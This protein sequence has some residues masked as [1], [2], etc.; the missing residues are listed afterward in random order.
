[1]SCC[2]WTQKGAVSSPYH[3]LLVPYKIR[4]RSATTVVCYSVSVNR[5]SYCPRCYARK[6]FTRVYR[7][8]V[9]NMWSLACG[10][11]I[12][13]SLDVL[14]MWMLLGRSSSHLLWTPTPYTY[15]YRLSGYPCTKHG[16]Q[17]YSRI[18]IHLSLTLP[19]TLRRQALRS[20]HHER[21]TPVRR[22]NAFIA[23]WEAYVMIFVEP[24]MEV[25]GDDWC[26]YI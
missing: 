15:G 16:P 12:A 14:I 22:R 9:E 4:S 18:H 21:F 7:M 2:F 13:H 19:S 17:P 25:Y 3:S 24:S 8:G 23:R 6:R 1:M 26:K 11:G 20:G 10:F 5:S